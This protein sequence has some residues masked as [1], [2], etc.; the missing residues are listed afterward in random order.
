MLLYTFIVD[1][2]SE[3][4]PLRVSVGTVGDVHSVDGTQE[5]YVMNIMFIVRIFIFRIGLKRAGYH[6]Q[7]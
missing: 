3:S 6:C 1:V 4:L 5:R 7:I 2:L